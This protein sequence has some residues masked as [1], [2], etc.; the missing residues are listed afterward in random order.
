MAGIVRIGM[1]I[2]IINESTGIAVSPFI[3][4]I[5]NSSGGETVANDGIAFLDTLAHTIISDKLRSS[6]VAVARTNDVAR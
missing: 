3:V 2:I 4:R 6:L 1:T 5:D